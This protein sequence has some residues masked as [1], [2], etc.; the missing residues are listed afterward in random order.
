MLA[1]EHAFT[2]MGA[3]S[4]LQPLNC[5]PPEPSSDWIGFITS[6]YFFIAFL[7]SLY[8]LYG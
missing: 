3:G 8:A 6:I 4:S 2:V 5:P 1:C 7:L